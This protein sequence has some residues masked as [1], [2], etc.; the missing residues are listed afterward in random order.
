M[1]WAQPSPKGGGAQVRP[2]SRAGSQGEGRDKKVESERG[3]SVNREH[4][5]GLPDFQV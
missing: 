3:S 4:Q 5:L 1:G 2:F